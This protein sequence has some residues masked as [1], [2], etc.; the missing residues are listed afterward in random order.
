MLPTAVGGRK[1]LIYNGY[2]PQFRYKGQ[3]NDVVVVIPD[4]RGLAPGVR[5]DVQMVFRAPDFQVGRLAINTTFTLAEGARNVAIG[6]ITNILREELM[7]ETTSPCAKP[8]VIFVDVDDTLVRSFG[9]KEIPIGHSIDYV[10]RMYNDGHSLYCW[11]RGGADYA[12]DVAQRLGILD[13]FICFLPKP[14]TVLDDRLDKFLDY[15]EF[16]H[17]NNAS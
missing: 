7:A 15:C 10:R 3:D 5:A 12:R 13:C 11:S 16:I 6:V 14:D 8:T 17:P 4:D 2:R 1:S 9:T